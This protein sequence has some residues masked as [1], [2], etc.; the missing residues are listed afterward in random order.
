[1]GVAL[2][3]SHFWEQKP[4]P[5]VPFDVT[6][7]HVVRRPTALAG[8]RI[9]TAIRA[10]LRTTAISGDRTVTAKASGRTTGQSETARGKKQ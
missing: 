5:S 9:V 4:Q 3:H 8:D 10:G 2:K 7:P 6:A 1:M